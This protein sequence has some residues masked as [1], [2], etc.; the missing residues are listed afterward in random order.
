MLMVFLALSSTQNSVSSLN[1]LNRFCEISFLGCN[2]LAPQ[3]QTLTHP[4]PLPSN[5][6]VLP[7]MLQTST[8]AIPP[9]WKLLLTPCSHFFSLSTFSHHLCCANVMSIYFKSAYCSFSIAGTISQ[10]LS[11]SN[12]HYWTM[13]CLPASCC[14]VYFSKDI[15]QFYYFLI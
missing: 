15:N 7:L 4:I 14:W 9:V 13:L 6:S 11:L 5:Q 10:N 3:S 1:F 8:R 2:I 12:L